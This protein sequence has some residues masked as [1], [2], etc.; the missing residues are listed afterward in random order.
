MS[1]KLEELERQMIRESLE[2]EPFTWY[3]A[4]ENARNNG[5]EEGKIDYKDYLLALK[6]E[7]SVEKRRQAFKVIQGGK[8]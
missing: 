2:V 6:H 4:E 8:K 3:Q 5:L 7:K 1:D